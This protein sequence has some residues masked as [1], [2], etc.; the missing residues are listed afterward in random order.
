LG[1][2]IGSNKSALQERF[3]WFHSEW[4]IVI[5]TLLFL[6]T[7]TIF[8]SSAALTDM[9]NGLP[10]EDII[11]LFISF[12]L[13]NITASL[14]QL[15]TLLVVSSRQVH[16]IQKITKCGKVS[17][18]HIVSNLLEKYEN[19]RKGVGPLY[20][21]EF[22]VHAPIILCF[23]YFGLTSAYLS[24]VLWSSGKIIWSSLTLIHIC[25]MSEYCYDAV[26]DLVPAIRYRYTAF[27]HH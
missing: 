20:T 25:L 16:F 10:T 2:F 23:A 27:L 1:Y 5:S 26:Q 11:H 18:V 9:A 3:A 14:L 8:L 21:I 13:M 15:T 19:M 17:S 22:C 24:M 12:Q 7:E 6:T 4:I